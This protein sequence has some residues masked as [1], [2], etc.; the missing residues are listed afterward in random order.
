IEGAI[1]PANLATSPKG[2]VAI[3]AAA[4]P[5]PGAR[6]ALVLLLI[7]NLFNYIDRQVLAAVE[8]EIARELFP[9]ATESAPPE[10][11]ADAESRMGWLSSAFLLTYMAMAPVFGALAHRMSRWLL[12]CFG[13]VCWSLASGAS[14]WNWGPNLVFAYWMLLLTRC[15]VGIGEAAYGP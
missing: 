14:G 10:V 6:T 3:S 15:F 9:E 12:I 2:R 11:R 4:A 13:V 1:M 8:P 5:L 7:I